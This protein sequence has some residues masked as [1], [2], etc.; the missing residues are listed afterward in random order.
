MAKIKFRIRGTK[1]DSPI[2]IRFSDG[3][4]KVFEIK[5][6]YF[7]NP[8]Y[9]NN[10]TGE[11]REVA[12][13]NEKIELQNNLNELRNA[14]RRTFNTSN[15]FTKEW[16]EAEVKKHHGV[17]LDI[18]KRPPLTWVIEKFIYHKE[19]SSEDEISSNTLKTF[20]VTLNRV[21]EF[22]KYL[23][24]THFIDEVGGK[25]KSDFVVWAKQVMKYQSQTYEKTL[26]QIRSICKYAKLERGITI[27]DSILLTTKRAKSVQNKKDKLP[28]IFLTI[29]EIKE[30][31]QFNGSE[32]LENARDWLVISCY[33]ACRVSDLMELSNSNL[34]RS[35]EGGQIIKY[36]QIKTGA[37]VIVPVLPEVAKIIDKYSGFPRPISHQKYN[38]YIKEVVKL[39][40]I[41]QLVKGGKMSKETNRKEFGEFPKYQLVTSHIG[42][43]SFATN[44]YGLISNH[45]IMQVTGHTTERQFLE[46]VDKLN[47]DHLKEF[48]NLHLLLDEKLKE[49]KVISK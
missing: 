7:C 28:P 31:V 38:D 27:D 16:F 35:I 12:M 46:Y 6:G 21:T 10:K 2:Y 22:E 26:K 39:S 37:E 24:K 4:D 47:E 42:R 30:V 14:I 11:V 25:F 43:R 48:N 13:F 32:S 19:Y 45:S 36:K 33:T 44:Y 8:E 17:I 41:N 40:G 3:R 9:F 23:G 1:P 5:S 29:N 20:H 18:E 34:H 15:E 49:D